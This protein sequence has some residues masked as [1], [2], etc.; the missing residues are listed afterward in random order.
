MNPYLMKL[1]LKLKKQHGKDVALCYL[2]E[3]KD[4]AIPTED[5]VLAA[6]TLADGHL[7]GHYALFNLI[8][9]L[10]G[11][12]HK[13]PR[14]GFQF[15]TTY[16]P[17]DS[18]VG[19]FLVQIQLGDK[20]ASSINY[21]VGGKLSDGVRRATPQNT[22]EGVPSV[23]C[24]LKE[25]E[26]ASL[27]KLDRAK[28]APLFIPADPPDT[29]HRPTKFRPD[30]PAKYDALPKKGQEYFD[31]MAMLAAYALPICGKE[32]AEDAMQ[33]VGVV[34][35]DARDGEILSWGTDLSTTFHGE[36]TAVRRWLDRQDKQVVE[37]ARVYTSLEPCNMCAG[38]LSEVSK[39]ILRLEVFY[40]QQDLGVSGMG[41]RPTALKALKVGEVQVEK[42][43]ESLAYGGT[44]KD[45]SYFGRLNQKVVD[46]N[47]LINERRTVIDSAKRAI[48]ERLDDLQRQADKGGTYA[49]K[50]KELVAHYHNTLNEKYKLVPG[51]TAM[52]SLKTAAPR[53]RLAKAALQLSLMEQSLREV[54][55]LN[56]DG[57]TAL[58]AFAKTLF[59]MLNQVSGGQDFAA[60]AN[61]YSSAHKG[62]NQLK[63]WRDNRHED[64]ELIRQTTLEELSILTP[65]QY[66]GMLKK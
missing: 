38:L 18:D 7:T 14:G 25:L 55:S 54:E 61:E 65:D 40:G 11:R 5:R 24:V 47:L 59:N 6:V 4:D 42:P 44:K 52:E 37:H 20:S 22:V 57:R 8:Q 49:K 51:A 34:I 63:I 1:A 66:L 39:K 35:V 28:V 32:I 41:R 9:H 21:A 10:K 31:G 60:L 64:I 48:K 50:Q 3:L 43:L 56:E 17:H 13:S 33:T 36:V 26:G 16:E 19:I 30:V 27:P 46:Y 15:Y 58:L 23:A 53:R 62:K 45:V 29:K 12:N 2:D